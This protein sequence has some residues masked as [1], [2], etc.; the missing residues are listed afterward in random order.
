MLSLLLLAAVGV[1][2][3][4]YRATKADFAALEQGILGAGKAAETLFPDGIEKIDVV[5][6]DAKYLYVYSRNAGY[7]YKKLRK[8]G[9]YQVY[10][11]KHKGK[12]TERELARCAGGLP[13]AG[14]VIGDKI[15]E[16]RFSCAPWGAFEAIQKKR[17]S[18]Y[19]HREGYFAS[20]L[21]EYG[22]Q[23]Q[24]QQ[25]NAIPVAVQLADRVGKIKLSPET[26][27]ESAKSEAF[28]D[29]C[30]L[31]GSKALYPK[32]Y[33]RMK[34]R[35]E[36]VNVEKSDDSYGHDAGLR[37]AVELDKEQAVAKEKR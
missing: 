27:L 28:A 2:A 1:H 37:A 34:Q 26:D 14:K 6:Y 9:K 18:I 33:D 16:Q 36:V 21:H 11:V 23:Y 4:G 35:G 3:G 5:L 12:L 15:A 7:K 30:E 32:H 19:Q 25:P 10:R 24:K 13:D 20:V 8:W 17:G 22:H 31:K 29:W